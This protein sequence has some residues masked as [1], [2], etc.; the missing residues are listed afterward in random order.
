MFM[1]NTLMPENFVEIDSLQHLEISR[2]TLPT[3]NL[4]QKSAL[5]LSL[6]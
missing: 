3:K 2:P 6:F 4:D 5:L 1:L